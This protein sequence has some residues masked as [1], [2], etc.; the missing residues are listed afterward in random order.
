MQNLSGIAILLSHFFILSSKES[1]SEDAWIPPTPK[2]G[3]NPSVPN[4]HTEASRVAP[5]LGVLVLSEGFSSVKG[6]NIRRT[7]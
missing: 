7:P 2:L 1:P 5:F 4:S 6:S 3:L